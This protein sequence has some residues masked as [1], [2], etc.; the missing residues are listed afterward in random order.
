MKKH[1][2]WELSRKLPILRFDVILLD[3]W[4]IKQCLLHIRVFFGG[5][6]KK[7]CFDLFIQWL[8]KQM[9]NIYRSHFQGHTKAALIDQSR[10]LSFGLHCLTGYRQRACF[11]PPHSR[12]RQK[13]ALLTGWLSGTV[14]VLIAFTNLTGLFFCPFVFSFSLKYTCFDKTLQ[15]FHRTCFEVHVVLGEFFYKCLQLFP[16]IFVHNLC[17]QQMRNYILLLGFKGLTWI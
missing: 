5:K 9:T 14:D 2:A 6:T 1:H 17:G 11:S 13:E 4:P 7:P 15:C 12:R 3:D 16:T 8:I 10:G